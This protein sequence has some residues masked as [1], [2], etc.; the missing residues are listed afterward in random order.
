[1][2]TATSTTFALL[3][4]V[5]VTGCGGAVGPQRVTGSAAPATTTIG[6]PPETTP[7][8]APEATS[9]AAPEDPT[10]TPT[11]TPATEDSTEDPPR[12]T[13]PNALAGTWDGDRAQISFSRDGDVTIR[14]KQGGGDSG[15]V[16]IAGSSMTL[17]LSGGVQSVDHW[18]I[19]RFDAGYGYEFFNLTLDGTSY[20]RDVPK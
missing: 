15:T 3:L 7:A 2:R 8:P 1:M 18:E 4:A 19:T 9:S 20:V 10:P 17:H 5:V 6:V 13:V 12:T 16:V 11:P 14:F